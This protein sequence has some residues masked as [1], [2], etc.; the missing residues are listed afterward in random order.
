MSRSW[1]LAAVALAFLC[2]FA[3]TYPASGSPGDTILCNYV[4]PDCLSNHWLMVWVAEQVRDGGSILHNDRYYWPVGDAP[5][6]AGNGSEGF[7]YLPFHLLWGWPKGATIYLVAILTLNGIA[8]YTLARAAGASRAA[9]LTAVPSSALMLYAIHELGAGRFSQVSF[10]WTA[11]FLA[12]WLRFLATPSLPRAFGAATLL[13][14]TSLFYWYYGL[15]AVLAGGVLLIGHVVGAPKRARPPA[16]ALVAFSVTFLALVAPLLW[17]FL[18]YWSSIPG[19]GEEVFPHPE[20]VG[21]SSWPALPF[22]VSGGRHAGRALPFTVVILAFVALFD[23]ER[24]RVVFSLWA[25]ALLFSALMAGALLPYGPFELIYGLAG[26]LRRFWWPYR[27]VIVMNLA[28]VTLAAL[29]AQ[30]LLRRPWLLVLL[31]LSIPAQLAVQGAPWRAQFSKADLSDSFYPLLRDLP[32]TLLIEPPLA[33]GVVSAQTTLV[34]QLLHGKALLAGHAMWV[35]RVRPDEWDTFVAANSFLTEMQ[36]LDRG[37]LAD[38]FT[39]READ[40]RALI[41][42]GA[43]TYVV[44]QEY[45]PLVLRPLVNAYDALFTSLFGAPVHAGKRVKAW[46]A[47]A[48]KEGGGTEPGLMATVPIPPF[49]W[50]GALHFGG[51]TLSLQAPRPPSIVFSVPPPEEG[52]RKPPVPKPG[53]GRR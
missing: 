17:V 4:H 14:V 51:P 40:L 36:R 44:N 37:E 18:R 34:Y 13:A 50:P 19:T 42:A 6:L 12:A 33:P 47:S 48:W 9:S 7:A 5:W 1:T 23:K 26:P 53:E 25:V 10:C 28:L 3:A 20:A 2:A 30:L 29:G 31:A 45:F 15:F 49:V 39:F 38:T 11:F 52:A 8:G 22:L 21:D 43:L 24:R 41:D 46:D 27:H 35:A 32:G 16:S